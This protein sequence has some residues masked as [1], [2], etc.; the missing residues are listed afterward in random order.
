MDVASEL[1]EGAALLRD[2]LARVVGADRRRLE[3]RL[4]EFE[5]ASDAG[6]ARASPPQRGGRG[7]PRRLSRTA[8]AATRYDQELEVVVDRPLA[9]FAAWYEL[10]PGPRAPCPAAQAPS[11]T[12]SSGC[13]RSRPWASTCSTCRR[14]TRSGGAS[15]RGATTRSR[16]A[17]TTRARRGPSAT[18]RAGTRRSTPALGT[19]AD[20]R[21]FLRAARD[22]GL[23]IALDY[24][25][26]CSPD[27]P[28]VT[29]HPEWFHHRPDGTI[30]YAE[31]PPKKYQDI[32]PLN[33]Y[34]R[35]REA[36]WEEAKGI[37]LFWIEQGDPDLPRGQSAH[38]ADPVLVVADLRRSSPFTPT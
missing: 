28:W 22:H 1:L 33:F 11:A 6:P 32:Y 27:H 5:A 31:N 36:L 3:A 17:P 26:Q 30:K 19:L 37:L 7:D 13:R 10:F 23:E 2:A 20:F 29:E 15:G 18:S 24:A 12:A 38:Q 16:P 14:S 8:A 34:S 9:R 4:A 25:L 21:A 35:E